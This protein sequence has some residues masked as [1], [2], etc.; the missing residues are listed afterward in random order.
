MLIHNLLSS[1]SQWN[2]AGTENQSSFPILHLKLDSKL[3]SA[4]TSEK[5]TLCAPRAHSS[6]TIF[7]S[8]IPNFILFALCC[9]VSSC[10]ET[11]AK[12]REVKFLLLAYKVYPSFLR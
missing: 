5:V 10:F 4:I 3:N 2:D 12:D 6:F 1:I 7:H 8:L 11:I 9:V